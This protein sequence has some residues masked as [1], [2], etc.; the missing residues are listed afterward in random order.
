MHAASPPGSVHAL[1]IQKLR[2]PS[3]SFWSAWEEG[4]LQA[5]GALKDL[6]DGD[7]EL[8]SLRTTRAVRGRGLGTAVLQHLLSVAI[9]LGYRQVL[10]E[11]GSQE[12]FAPA[13]RLYARHGFTVCAP[14][15]GY[16]QDTSSVFMEL[17]LDHSLA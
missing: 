16:S 14:F 3:I 4:A 2:D 9:D 13:R 17:L 15:G 10:L 11:T 12:F 1:D 8:K 5:C 6:G 7:A